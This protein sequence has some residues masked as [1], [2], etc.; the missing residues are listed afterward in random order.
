MSSAIM[1]GLAGLLTLLP[2]GWSRTVAKVTEGWGTFWT[3][4]VSAMGSGRF[5]TLSSYDVPI[6]R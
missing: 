6:K 3:K 4:E 1:L 5:M 2:G